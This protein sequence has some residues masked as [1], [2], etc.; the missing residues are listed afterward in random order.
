[1]VIGLFL[2]RCKDVSDVAPVVGTTNTEYANTGDTG[3][4]GYF[5][6]PITSTGGT[7]YSFTLTRQ[8]GAKDISHLI[9]GVNAYCP[10]S[11]EGFTILAWTI[12]GVE[13]GAILSESSEGNG[14]GC[15]VSM[16]DN[17]FKLDFSRTFPV[18]QPI[19]FTFTTSQVVNIDTWYI[20]VKAG[21]KC[22]IS[23]VDG[24][25]C[26]T[27]PPPAGLCSLSQGYFFAKPGDTWTDTNGVKH[28]VTFGA[29][30]YSQEE[31]KA[32]WESSN[33]GGKLD[34]KAA[35]L[36]ATTIKLNFDLKGETIPAELEAA[37]V[38]IDN[39]FTNVYT[40]KLTPTNIPLNSNATAALKTAANVLSKYITDNHCE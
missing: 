9:I 33:K 25:D 31:A 4:S 37:L 13:Q 12:A 18:G 3:T 21:N 34:V 24:N 23:G 10:N 29:N 7:T 11:L 39:Y 8:A 1:M 20:A 2:V 14:T 5:I 40:A 17:F 32:I 35:F 30:T 27:T 22:A 38:V 26:G 16:F 28:T 36:Q 15:D 19:T 6:S